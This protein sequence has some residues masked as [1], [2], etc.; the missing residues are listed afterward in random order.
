[1]ESLISSPS[2]LQRPDQR[3]PPE[4]PGAFHRLVLG[5]DSPVAQGGKLR[6]LGTALP[7]AG[8]KRWPGLALAGGNFSSS[9]LECS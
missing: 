6:R 7:R 5:F 8:R 4:C 1:M 9:C 2:R 3:C